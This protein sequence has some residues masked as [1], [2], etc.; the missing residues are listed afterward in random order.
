MVKVKVK[1]LKEGAIVP[2]YAH[3]GDAALDLYSMEDYIV[4]AEERVLVSTGIAME[5]P[6]GYFSS[7][8]G[9][10]GLAWKNGIA[11]L[12]GVVDYGYRGEY[13]V[14]FLNTGEKDFEVKRG[15]RI[16]QVVIAPVATAEIEVVDELSE[17]ERGDGAWGSTGG[18]DELRS[19]SG[20]VEL[21]RTFLAKYIPDDID[22]FDVLEDNYFPRDVEHP[23]LRLRKKGG[24]M[25]M[26]KKFPKKKGDKSEFI[27]ETIVLCNEEYD[28]L[29]KNDGKRHS[30]RRYSYDY[31]EGIKCDVDVYQGDL[32]GLV[33]VD[34][35]FDSVDMKSNF[36]VPDFCLVEV[37]GKDFL[38]G[39]MLC[40]KRYEDIEERLREL[41]YKKL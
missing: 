29:N 22:S 3:L 26:T 37:T 33:L 12:G 6:K 1:K 2:R 15:D 28:A 13:G 35:E 11:I 23:V 14:V 16:A 19:E 31:G 32:K 39:G 27:E 4:P 10:S 36:I 41:G 5:L 9:R 18:S 21:E 40:G 25:V 38:A 30:K 20:E 8:R 17:S 7:I 34:F 24:K